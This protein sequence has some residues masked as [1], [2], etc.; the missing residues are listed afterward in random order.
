M[1]YAARNHTLKIDD[2]T[3]D[4]AVFG[5]G[6]KKMLILPGL[7]LRGVKGTAIPLALMFNM[8]AKE[9]TVY[10]FDRK[11]DIPEGYT[12][13]DI[14][15]DTAKA[16]GLLGIEKADVFG[17]SQGGMIAQNLAIDHPER[18]NKLVLSVTTSRNNATMT[19]TIGRWVKMAENNDHKAIVDDMMPMLY[20]EAS[21]RKYR[22]LMPILE[23]LGKPHNMQRFVRMAKA[24]FTINTYDNL[25][26]ITCP[27][28]VIGGRLDKVLSAEASEEIAEKLGCKLHIYEDLGHALYEE[29]DDFNHRVLNF[30]LSEE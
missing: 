2:T 23:L 5:H 1:L 13:R 4:Y 28:Y 14:A 16:M 29:A 25:E 22:I 3:M 8:F 30:F 17:V 19:E 12:V 20:S 7:N 9:Y 10:V 11:R 26:K 18:V 27:T 6:K 15:H 24:C 21:C